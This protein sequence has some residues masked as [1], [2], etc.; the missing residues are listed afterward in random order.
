MAVSLGQDAAAAAD[1]RLDE[2]SGEGEGAGLLDDTA[3]LR[4]LLD[5]IAAGTTD[6]ADETWT[7]PVAHYR[8]A[9][10]LAAE[11]E[12]VLRRQPAVL[13]PS[14][15]LP[16]PGSYLA[17]EVAGVPLVAVRGRDG[18]VRA[19]RNSCR[20][21]GTA[22]AS[23]SGCEKQ[24]SC[25][26][27]G[28]VY[29]LDGALRHVPDA[30][31]FP[32]LDRADRGLVPVRSEERAGLVL[33]VQDEAPAG[34]A[35]TIGPLPP[36]VTADMT[37]AGADEAEI[38][39]NWK[40]FLEGFLEGYHL[41]ATHRGTFLPFGYDNVTVVETFGRHSR[42]SFPFRRIEALRSRPPAEWR[43]DG[44]GTFVH[45]LFPN[46]VV[47]RLSH[48]TTVVV[49]EPLAVDRTRLHTFR[50][51][52]P[53]PDHRPP[54]DPEAGAGADAATGSS[55]GTE[56]E[57]ALRRDVDFVTQ[58]AAEDLAMAYDVQRG[59]ASGANDVL[60]FGRFEGA[61]SHLH[62]QLHELVD[63]PVPPAT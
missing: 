10:R 52:A 2:P 47:V 32:G 34:E 48:H 46:T 39:C 23:G 13:C 54:G 41:K 55:S 43:L 31:G 57:A 1:H 33:V 61:L 24:L 62:R 36:L 12:R 16:G 45:H 22:V 25:P 42:V 49:L 63:G 8:S 26:Y 35:S 37:L 56:A 58:G 9:D 59:L 6:L 17:R 29:G 44:M 53:R 38:Q 11:V 60:T 4:R 51:A 50:L 5:H 15:A 28:W 14:A 27:H 18:V 40:V 20:H 19:F 30:Q 3:L 21:R 7:E